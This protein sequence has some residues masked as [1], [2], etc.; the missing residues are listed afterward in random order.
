MCMRRID[1][2]RLQEL[3]RLHRM[4]TGFRESARLLAMSPNTE[5]QYR[6]ALNAAGLF[7][8]AVEEL[9]L[10]EKLKAAVLERLPPATAPQQISSLERWDE[11]I[12]ALFELGLR[13]RA[14]YDRLRL[15]H[16]DF[17]GSY[18]AVKRTWRRLRRERGVRDRRQLLVP[19]ALTRLKSYRA[20]VVASRSL[21]PPLRAAGACDGGTDE[22]GDASGAGS[23]D[24][25]A[26]HGQHAAG[27]SEDPR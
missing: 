10:L 26:V 3:V 9:P 23:S 15:E 20:G 12:R 11:A 7:D 1:M 14:L 6:T 25:R 2:D 16:Q 13:P 17:E 21:L 8:G 18:W 22:L 24:Q 5:R 19:G 27:E 4:G